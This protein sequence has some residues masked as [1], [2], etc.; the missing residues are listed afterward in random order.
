MIKVKSRHSQAYRFLKG[1]LF[2]RE[3]YNFKNYNLALSYI[4]VPGRSKFVPDL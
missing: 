1:T 4:C 3:G 2:L